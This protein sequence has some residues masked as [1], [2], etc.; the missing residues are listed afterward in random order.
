MKI[1]P[2]VMGVIISCG[3]AGAA[4][5]DIYSW[6]DAQGVRHFSN[7]APPAGA[8]NVDVTAELPYRPPTAQELLE[9]QKAELLAAAQARIE[10]MEAESLEKLRDVKRQAE[11]ARQKAEQ[12]RQY[13]EEQLQA[14]AEKSAYSKSRVL[15]SGYYP[16][17]R[18]NPYFRKERIHS[19]FRARPELHKK[20][21]EPRSPFKGHGGISVRKHVNRLGPS[22]RH[23][24]LHKGVHRPG[25][26]AIDGRSGIMLRIR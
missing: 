1:F 5:A 14:A 3:L 17:Y 25:G 12:A 15:Y 21:F 8:A 2:A 13:A 6:T 16:Y 11:E 9:S 18:P 10:E 19:H 24:A 20:H 23:P 22:Q 26:F 4:A 7:H